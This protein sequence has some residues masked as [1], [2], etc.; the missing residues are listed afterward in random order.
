MV[1]C[2]LMV[3]L[4]LQGAAAGAVTAL[5]PL[6]R[7]AGADPAQVLEDVRRVAVAIVV[8]AHRHDGAERHH[9]ADAA[10]RADAVVVADAWRSS[11][12]GDID[13]MIRFAQS[14]FLALLP[15]GCTAPAAVPERG[16][17]GSPRD[18]VATTHPE[19]LDRPP[20]HR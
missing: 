19:P 5:G 2:L 9:H 8:V 15:D 13:A 6:H 14:G 3:L 12:N 16:F 4:P 18:T 1:A 11:G 20:R 7:H 17:A 10:S